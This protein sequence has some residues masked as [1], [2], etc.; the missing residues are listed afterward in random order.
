L[1]KAIAREP[2]TWIG[3]PGPLKRNYQGFG[4]RQID[5]EHRLIYQVK[6]NEVC[7]SKCRFHYD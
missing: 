6:D 4:S 1:L 7:I 3:K 5:G 2:Y